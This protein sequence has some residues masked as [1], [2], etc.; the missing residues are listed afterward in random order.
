MKQTIRALCLLFLVGAMLCQPET[1]FDGATRALGIWVQAVV[2]ALFPFFITSELLINAGVTQLLSRWVTPL[3]RPLFYLPGAAAIAV[4]MGFLSGSPTGAA[5]T[6]KLYQQGYC[7]KEEAQRLLAFTNNAG[8]L[9]ILSATAIGILHRPEVGLWLCLAHYP[10][11]LIYGVVLGLWAR[12]RHGKSLQR[13]GPTAAATYLPLGPL[14]GQSIKSAVTTICQVGGFMVLFAVLTQLLQ[15]FGVLAL[16]ERCL[17]PLCRLLGLPESLAGS[18]S[19]G[20]FEMTLGISHLETAAAPLLAKTV[21]ASMILAWNG[22]CVQAQI[23]GVLA[24]T[25]LDSK[26]YLIGRLFHCFLAPLLLVSLAGAI[27]ASTMT[28]GMILPNVWQ[29]LTLGLVVLACLLLLG[30]CYQRKSCR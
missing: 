27:P 6:A 8:P 25:D 16:L 14:L 1:V 2:P 17:I 28:L 21:A 29:L 26:L 20:L 10:I 19:Y 12:C 13:Q 4:V 3:M 9:Y 30:R 23:M 11:N 15:G 18:L 22:L 5:V 24:G 7:T